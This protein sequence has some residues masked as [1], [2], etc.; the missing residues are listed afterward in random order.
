MSPFGLATGSDL[1]NAGVIP[2]GTLP[3][4]PAS[5]YKGVPD[6]G[7]FEQGSFSGVVRSIQK[8][9]A[10]SV[11]TVSKSFIKMSSNFDSP[12]SISI[13]DLSGRIVKSKNIGSDKIPVMDLTGIASGTYLFNVSAGKK[14]INSNIFTVK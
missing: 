2:T 6:L 8:N 4:T 12:V 11:Y 13:S 3:F 9:D 5:Y 14:V 1:L 10:T 7:P